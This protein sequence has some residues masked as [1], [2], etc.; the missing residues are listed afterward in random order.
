MVTEKGASALQWVP[1]RKRC[2]LD[3]YKNDANC[4]EFKKAAFQLNSQLF[5]LI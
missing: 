4:K 1:L 2:L 5:K 3:R